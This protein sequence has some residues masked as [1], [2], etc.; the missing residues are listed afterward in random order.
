LLVVG[1]INGCFHGG[2]RQG[3]GLNIFGKFWQ[4]LLC[5]AV[6]FCAL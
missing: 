2:H 3:Q 6:V 4:L 1:G 5:L